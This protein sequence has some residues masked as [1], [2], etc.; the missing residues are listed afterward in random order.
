MHGL[1]GWPVK[2]PI[3]KP[4]DDSNIVGFRS[5]RNASNGAVELAA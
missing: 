4:N 1:I 3:T 5:N 2:K